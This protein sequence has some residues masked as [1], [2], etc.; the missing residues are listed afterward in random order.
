MALKMPIKISDSW[1]SGESFIDGKEDGLL[2]H[3]QEN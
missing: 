2:E 3:F 1:P